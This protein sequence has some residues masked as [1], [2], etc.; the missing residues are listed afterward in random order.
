MLCTGTH[1][2][3]GAVHSNGVIAQTQ[4]PTDSISINMC[5]RHISIANPAGTALAGRHLFQFV[6]LQIVALERASLGM[7]MTNGDKNMRLFSTRALA[8]AFV[9]VSWN[10]SAPAVNAQ[11]Q[12]PSPSLSDPSPNIPDQKLEAAAVALERVASLKRNYQEQIEAAAPSDRERIANEANNALQKAVTDQGL[13]VEEFNSI[14][15]VAQNDP[16]IREKL[17]RRIPPSSK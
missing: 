2:F 4:R 14:I 12:P 6:L 5:L 7:E 13:S 3:E 9:V 17:L 10:L 15:V 8:V 1:S 16:Q 11:V